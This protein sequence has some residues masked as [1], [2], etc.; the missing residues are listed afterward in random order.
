[1]TLVIKEDIDVEEYITEY[2]KNFYDDV[3]SPAG[4]KNIGLMA[5]TFAGIKTTA[6]VV[7]VDDEHDSESV[8]IV[9][10]LVF[11]DKP[12]LREL[13]T[14]TDGVRPGHGKDH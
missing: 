11:C 7:Q 8:K 6:I 1:M 2:H 4:F 5:V 9:P 10:I 12:E 3:I 13:L 14:D